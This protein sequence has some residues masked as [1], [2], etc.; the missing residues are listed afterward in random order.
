MSRD[1]SQPIFFHHNALLTYGTYL[2]RVTELTD[3]K[4]AEVYRRQA[5][6]VALGTANQKLKEQIEQQQIEIRELEADIEEIKVI[7]GLANESHSSDDDSDDDPVATFSLLQ[8]ENRELK[9]ILEAKSN[10]RRKN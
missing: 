6:I 4:C 8:K 10:S 5:N 7:N 9:Q 1:V 2:K 3:K